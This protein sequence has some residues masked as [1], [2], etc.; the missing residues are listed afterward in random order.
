MQN[1][2][3]IIEMLEKLSGEVG[4]LKQTVDH[5]EKLLNKIVDR[6]DDHERIF[7][8]IIQRLNYHDTLFEKMFEKTEEALL[9]KSKSN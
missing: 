5:E 3:K 9:C 6:L 2:D 1:Q 7:E 8:R 4:S